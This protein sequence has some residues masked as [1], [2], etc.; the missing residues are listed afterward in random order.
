MDIYDP[1]RS[2]STFKRNAFQPLR[3][4][5]GPNFADVSVNCARR[6]LGGVQRIVSVKYYAS[7]VVWHDNNLMI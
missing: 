5:A 4:K 3:N 1:N 7:P 6:F 2:T